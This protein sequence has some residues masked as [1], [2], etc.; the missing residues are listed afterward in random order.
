[1][2]KNPVSRPGSVQIAT[3]FLYGS[4]VLSGIAVL[5]GGGEASSPAVLGTLIGAILLGGF[6][7]AASQGRN[8]AR[9]A[10]SVLA[11]VGIVSVS[12]QGHVSS[13]HVAGVVA[14]L[15]AVIMLF[16]KQ[17]SAWF[18]QMTAFRKNECLSHQNRAEENK[19]VVVEVPGSIKHVSPATD[20]PLESADLIVNENNDNEEIFMMNLSDRSDEEF[21]EMAAKEFD[22]GEI[23]KG[24][25]LKAEVA[26]GGDSEKARLFCIRTRAMELAQVATGKAR[27]K[28]ALA[29]LRETLGSEVEDLGLEDNFLRQMKNFRADYPENAEVDEL[30]AEFECRCL[31]NS[32]AFECSH[33]PTQLDYEKRLQMYDSF[34]AEHPEHLKRHE[35]EKN[36][37]HDGGELENIRDRV[38]F[39]DVKWKAMGLINQHKHQEASD[40]YREYLALYGKCADKAREMVEETIPKLIADEPRRKQRVKRNLIIGAVVVAGL[41]LIIG[42]GV[43][44]NVQEAKAFAEKHRLA[45][46]AYQLGIRYIG[47]KNYS[48][49]LDVFQKATATGVGLA[50]YQI[51]CLY[52]AGLGVSQSFDNAEEWLRKA[53]QLGSDLASEKLMELFLLG[54]I[55]PLSSSE[56]ETWLL[57]NEKKLDAV[58]LYRLYELSSG[59]EALQWLEKSAG[60]GYVKARNMLGGE[61]YLVGQSKYEQGDYAVALYYY[62]KAAELNIAVAQ[63]QVGWMC[64]HGEG[65][66]PSPLIAVYWY[67]KAIEWGVVNFEDRSEELE[68][69][70]EDGSYNG[71][72][73]FLF[74]PLINLKD[75]PDGSADDFW[76]NV[77]RH[78]SGARE[79]N[80]RVGLMWYHYLVLDDERSGFTNKQRAERAMESNDPIALAAIFDEY[81]EVKRSAE[82]NS[83]SP[84]DFWAEVDQFS[85]GSRQ[86]NRMA[87]FVWIEYL[88]AVDKRTGLTN[89]Q[90]AEA[91]IESNHAVE[92]AAIFDECWRL[93]KVAVTFKESDG[94]NKERLGLVE[95]APE[96]PS[97]GPADDFW[98]LVDQ[99]SPGSREM[100]KRGDPVWIEYLDAVDKQTGL[101]NR[102]RA[103]AAMESN[104]PMALATIFD[105]CSRQIT[106]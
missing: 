85:P 104:D 14:R 73:Y 66:R 30:Q 95:K 81:K 27:E 53:D 23:S 87:D 72:D 17:S 49:A 20:T 60:Q 32:I 77:D 70:V 79:I 88:D 45:T 92:L 78:S 100:N 105:E 44:K 74:S 36:R 5:G 61:W 76:A 13:L 37:S 8:W 64:A 24:L 33:L 3:Y 63:Y 43:W 12:W 29:S 67:A 98:P 35:I 25:M 41:A 84:D 50:E 93:G 2:E 22:S 6:T 54:E 91:A 75:L 94:A 31:E 101:P 28:R 65:V 1:M 62:R 90:R 86:M 80:R 83:C 57:A 68:A 9:I 97:S 51:G 82:M 40:L 103:E 15:S 46:E 19:R 11:L 102:E 52:L 47:D 69:Q 16:Q 48:A 21:F 10:L 4:L 7:Y 38:A 58:H 99:Y 59:S 106:D 56:E 89:R 39:S 71:N 42:F 34:L 26:A 18:R 55:E 96:E